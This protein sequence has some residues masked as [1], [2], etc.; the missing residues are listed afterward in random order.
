MVR[1]DTSRSGDR[2]V[3]AALGRQPGRGRD[4]DEHDSA[5][6]LAAAVDVAVREHRPLVAVHAGDVDAGRRAALAAGM[7]EEVTRELSRETLPDNE[8]PLRIEVA[9]DRPERAL[10][11]R[12]DHAALIVLGIRRLH[13]SGPL[14]RLPVLAPLFARAAPLLGLAPLEEVLVWGSRCPVELVPAPT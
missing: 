1:G 13:R 8:I 7:T 11:E 4:G 5:G 6:V 3:V 12:S 2:P 10:L 14:D 9:T